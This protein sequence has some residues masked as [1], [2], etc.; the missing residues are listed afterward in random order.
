MRIKTVLVIVMLILT[1]IGKAQEKTKTELKNT[2]ITYIEKYD[3]IANILMNE[4]KIPA[5]IILGISL[6]ESGYGT[7]KLSVNKHNYFGIKKGNVYRSYENDIESFRDFCIFISKKKYY[8]KLK[9]NKILDYN[10]WISNIKS[11]GYSESSNWG[12][13]VSYYIEKYKLF[14]FDTLAIRTKEIITR[15]EPKKIVV[16]H[17][18]SY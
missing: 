15:L 11:G 12:L 9:E 10:I 18:L 5:S 16:V 17:S 6:H 14:R 8:L 4:F 2:P 13:K 3:S 1:L 7:S